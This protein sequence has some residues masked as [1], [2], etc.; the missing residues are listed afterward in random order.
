LVDQDLESGRLVTLA[1]EAIPSDSAFWLVTSQ[2]EFEK[3]EVKQFR[4][5]LLAELGVATEHRK[6]DAG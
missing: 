1:D 3:P 5:W 4:Q 2:T 6:R